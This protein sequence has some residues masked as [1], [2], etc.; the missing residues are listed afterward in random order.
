MPATVYLYSGCHS[1]EK[2]TWCLFQ[3]E[4]SFFGPVASSEFRFESRQNIFGT[5][6]YTGQ[7]GT[8]A[9]YRISRVLDS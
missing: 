4:Y 5:G 1:A 7:G 9:D 8:Y 2:A 3:C 6:N